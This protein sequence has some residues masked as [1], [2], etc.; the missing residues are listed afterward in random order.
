MTV[1]PAPEAGL[2]HLSYGCKI[3]WKFAVHI[4]HAYIYSRNL[5]MKNFRNACGKI[6]LF[7]PSIKKLYFIVRDVE[8][9]LLASEERE[10][11]SFSIHR[12]VYNL[13][14]MD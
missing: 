12:M 3:K 5:M 1:K 4:E 7:K 9:S 8:I 13:W 6:W 10:R 2:Q 11:L 14:I